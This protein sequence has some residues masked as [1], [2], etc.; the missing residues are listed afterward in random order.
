ME[1]FRTFEYNGKVLQLATYEPEPSGKPLVTTSSVNAPGS[2][3][4]EIRP[5]N[6]SADKIAPGESFT[7]TAQVNGKNIA[8]IFT[9]ILFYDKE[10]DQLY[11][12]VAREYIRAER[13]KVRGGVSYPVWE[14]ALNL[15]IQLTPGL[16]LIM[17]GFDSAF[18]FLFPEGYNSSDYHLDGL[19]TT[20]DGITQRRARILFGNDG[21]V[22]KLTAYKEQGSR[23]M[24]HAL[25]LKQGDQ[26]TPFIQI[27]TPPA[28]K[29]HIWQVTAGLSTPLT[30]RDEPFRWEAK[31]PIPGD[32]LVGLLVQDLD[33]GLAR[34]YAPLTLSE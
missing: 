20:A 5:I 27:L 10:L 17:D 11:G 12:P 21:G 3:K 29:D 34:Q 9:E 16:R 32:Y 22:K 24:P 33:G 31:P 30:Y 7:L 4:F 8:H 18:G 1:V 6:L 23:S 14:N 28:G 19:Y 15:T 13:N 25:T 2:G 26:F